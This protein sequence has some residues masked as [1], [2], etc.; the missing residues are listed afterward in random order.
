MIRKTMIRETMIRRTRTRGGNALASATARPAE[1]YESGLEVV[2]SCNVCRS[3]RILKVDPEFNLCHCDSCGYVF[4]SP[5]PS[6]AEVARFYSQAGKY[7]SWLQ[8]EHARDLLW[9]RRLRKL[10]PHR[11]PGSLLDIGAGIG[12]FLH[13][14]QLLFSQVTGTEVSSSAVT[15]AKE[16]YGLNLLAGQVEGLNLP[17]SS[18]DN[19]TL[20]HVLEHVHD[21]AMLVDLCRDLLRPKGVLVI[22]VPNDVLSWSSTVKKAGKRLRLKPFQKFSPVLGI[23]RAGLSREIHLSHFTPAVL[24]KLVERSGLAVVEESLDPYFVS[25]GVRRIVD[26][27]YHALHR[28][29]H[30]AFK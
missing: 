16:R 26:G 3:D 21:P 28:M 15:I 27:A 29:L 1:I 11:A 6:V 24:R 18:F 25:S 22:A 19:I 14:A 10:L 8:Q 5:R 23:A 4:D 9:K 7:D 30:A 2:S 12:Q 13:H 20:F 17:P